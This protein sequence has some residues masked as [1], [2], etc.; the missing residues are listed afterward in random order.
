MVSTSVSDCDIIIAHI[1]Q[2]VNSF[3]KIFSVFGIFLLTNANT[4]VILASEIPIL[5]FVSNIK[6]IKIV[7]SIKFIPKQIILF[8]SEKSEDKMNN[9][10]F[11]R[12][13][14]L[15]TRNRSGMIRSYRTSRTFPEMLIMMLDLI[16]TA[17]DRTLDILFRPA[18]CR[19][20]RTVLAISCIVAFLC[21]I[22]AL[23]A[24]V[25]SVLTSVCLA[26]ILVAVEV[27]CL[28]GN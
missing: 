22:G 25:I 26:I 27:L 28:K 7:K 9:A 15:N 10:Y 2:F 16:L 3:L 4:H 20:V 6:N 18:V 8:V 14:K 19:M 13:N 5:E 12:S 21:L 17:I 11:K 23:E 1:F 24:G